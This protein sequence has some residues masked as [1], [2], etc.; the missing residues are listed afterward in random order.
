MAACVH[1]REQTGLFWRCTAVVRNMLL[2]SCGDEHMSRNGHRGE[3]E[4]LRRRSDAMGTMNLIT[5]YGLL[6]KDNQAM[7]L[8]ANSA[9]GLS[10]VTRTRGRSV[11]RGPC[12]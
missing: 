4:V 3:E 9:A 8:G 12:R 1:L 11:I 10:H 7:G 2:I 5:L 6:W